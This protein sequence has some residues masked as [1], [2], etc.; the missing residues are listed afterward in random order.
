MNDSR[1]IPV[2]RH[3]QGFTLLEILIVCGVIALLTAI[4]LPVFG[5]VRARAH[6]AT[7]TSNLKQ[8]GLSIQ[9]Y[10]VDHRGRYPHK[11]DAFDNTDCAW[12]DRLL[13]YTRSTA[14][15][16]C[17][18][19]SKILY[20]PGCGPDAPTDTG[21]TDEFSSTINYDGSYDM[22]AL[23]RLQFPNETHFQHPST[24][25]SV[26]DGD[27]ELR[28]ASL[29]LNPAEY[30]GNGVP[31]I[32]QPRHQGGNNVLFL[33]GRVKWLSANAMKDTSLWSMA[34]PPAP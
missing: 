12:A 31:A 2:A 16:L 11:S 15:F 32:K 27:G 8:I 29:E 23:K 1:S 34:A 26:F 7:C 10:A 24:T 13:P 6:S 3:R 33:D 5:K 14:V 22:N 19:S 20:V 4:L 30:L 21:E 17:P 9:M 28:P 18:A 25:I